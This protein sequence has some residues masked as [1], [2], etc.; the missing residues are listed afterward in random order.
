M[1]ESP[2]E[3]S[4]PPCYDVRILFLR[5]SKSGNVVDCQLFVQIETQAHSF[6]NYNLIKTFRTL[7]HF[8]VKKALQFTSFLFC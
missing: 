5:I 4:K 3:N 1:L 7:S 8:S 2:W 6:I